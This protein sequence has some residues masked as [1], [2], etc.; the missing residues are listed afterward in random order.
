MVQR[1]RSRDSF[2][3]ATEGIL[4]CFRSQRHMQIH[5]AML[6]L[7][8][9]S[10]LMLALDT[11]QMLLL[12][13]CISLVIATEMVNT[14]VETVVDMVTRTYH[15]LAKLAKDVAA[16]AVLIAS[17][18]AVVAGTLILFG[19]GP[20]RKIGR[21]G[22]VLPERSPDIGVV[23]VVGLM[24]LTVG[25]IISKLLQGRSNAGVLHGGAVSGH[26]AIGFFLAMTIVFTSESR[27]VSLLAFLMAIIIAQSRVEAGVH[28]IQEVIL[29]AVIAVFLTASVYWM[30]PRFRALLAPPATSSSAIRGA[31]RDRPD[32]I[33]RAVQRHQRPRT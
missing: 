5:F 9:V 25:V 10:G 28:S 13:F 17:A 1:K 22:L 7:V 3:Y 12:L 32:A 27:F 20:I 26:S 2:K 14:A 24:V 30:M 31:V 6:V 19:S 18:N 11:M 33:G 8:L 29:G 21:G 16:G 23:V 4:H 15:P